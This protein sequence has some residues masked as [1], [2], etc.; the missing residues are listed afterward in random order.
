MG[1]GQGELAIGVCI[2]HQHIARFIIVFSAGNADGLKTRDIILR[3][4]KPVL[5]CIFVS[6]KRD[7][8]I[9][10]RRGRG[11]VRIVNCK[12]CSEKEN[13]HYLGN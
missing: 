6:P 2:D 7:D 1:L 3:F 9:L 12:N 10:A 4:S 5:K 13:K 8:E 11:W